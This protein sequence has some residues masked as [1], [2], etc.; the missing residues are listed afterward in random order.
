MSNST[1]QWYILY[2]KTGCEKKVSNLLTRKNIVNYYPV[3]RLW[4]SRKKVILE[5]LFNSYVFVQVTERDLLN[6]RLF[7]GVINLGYWL[8]KP[9]IIRDEE[10][11]IMKR[12]MNEYSSVK[13]EKIPFNVA[14]TV[15][16]VGDSLMEQK[17]HVISVK[18]NTVKIVLPSL[19]YMMIADLEKANV[20]ILTAAK[21]S[22]SLL[23][24]FQYAV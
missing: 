16:V 10:I 23:E 17:G 1:K 2:T 18:N 12:F 13:L 8:G 11:E 14:G 9:A 22:F 6:I 15:R 3:K 7:D 5:P 19:G 4:N 21:K 20:E 24:R